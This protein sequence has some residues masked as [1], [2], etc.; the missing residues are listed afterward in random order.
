MAERADGAAAHTVMEDSLSE[1]EWARYKAAELAKLAERN[2][3]VIVPIGST[4]QHG[5]HLPTQVDTRLVTEVAQRAARVMS[6][7]HPTCRAHDP[8]RHERASHVPQRHH[9]ARLRHDGGGPGVRVPFHLAGW[10]QAHL[11]P[12]RPRGQYRRHLHIHQ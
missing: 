6:S 8:L 9:Y 5:P 7:G 4:E 12:Q 10:L 1:I 2:A 11:R 3:I